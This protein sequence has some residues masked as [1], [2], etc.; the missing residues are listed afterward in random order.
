MVIEK[1]SNI[2]DQY[3]FGFQGQEGDGEIS[4]Q[5]NSYAFKYRIHD[6]RLGRFLSVDPLFEDYAFNSTYAFSENRV[7]DGIDLEGLEFFSVHGVANKAENFQSREMTDLLNHLQSK[8]T[9][10]MERNDDFAWNIRRPGSILKMNSVL[11]NA[12]D[13]EAASEMLVNHVMTHKVAGEDV[14]LTGFSGGALVA[15][16]AA[17]KLYDR[18]GMQVNIMAINPPAMKDKASRYHPL[19]NTGINDMFVSHTEGDFVP[20]LMIGAN[21]TYISENLPFQSEYRQFESTRSGINAHMMK[22]V[23]MDQVVNLN[24]DKLSPV[25]D[26]AKDPN[27]SSGPGSGMGS[28]HLSEF[29]NSDLEN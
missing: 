17:Q 7:I 21:N 25:P 20:G 6:P 4:G 19:N 27:Y 22:N 3:R 23:N 14:T 10:R 1:R 5:G 16:S 12:K 11:F 28:L 13:I 29:E 2:N 15:Y 8:S 9:N 18:Y 24:I 26:S